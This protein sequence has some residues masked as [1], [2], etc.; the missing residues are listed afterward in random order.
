MGRLKEETKARVKAGDQTPSQ[1]GDIIRTFGDSYTAFDEYKVATSLV[2][3][4][5]GTGTLIL[6]LAAMIASMP[7]IQKK[8]QDAIEAEYGVYS[9]T[10][11][12]LAFADDRTGNENPDPLDTDRVEYITALGLEAG[13]YYASTR[14]GFPRE[15][16]E[17]VTIDGVLIP[18][19]TIVAHNTY[20][21]NRDPARYDYV[22]EFI[23]ERWLDGHYGRVSEKGAR[24]GLPHLTNGAGR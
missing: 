10:L 20:S 2:G 11:C 12:T 13:R 22:D 4:G 15:T 7:E 16:I 17:D 1:L 23:P 18:K 21:V 24:V 8:A 3:S 9:S 6:W 14:L 5:M 19:G